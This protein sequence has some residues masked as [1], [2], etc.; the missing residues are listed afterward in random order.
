M[1]EGLLFDLDGVIVDTAR[2]HYRAWKRLAD[3]LGIPF[4]KQDNERL[5]GVSRLQSL[6]IVLSIGKRVVPAA[7]KERLCDRKNRWYLESIG[8]L[9]PS[10]LLPGALDFLRLVR[11]RGRRT[12]LASASKNAPAIVGRLEIAE[13]F[14]TVVD[15]SQIHR[16]KPDPEIFLVCAERLKLP[17]ANCVVFEDAVAGIEAAHAAGMPAVGIGDPA[18]LCSADIVVPRLS[19]TDPRL[20]DFLG[21]R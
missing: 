10:D 6:E 5:K 3:E 19:V 17:R 13:H 12:A 2:L 21:L 4:T 15:G 16:T 11:S 20:L 9:T 8:T 7:E 14:D 18:V 1:K